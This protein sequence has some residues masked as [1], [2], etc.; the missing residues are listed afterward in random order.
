[1]SET[2]GGGTMNGLQ[3]LSN[4]GAHAPSYTGAA[5]TTRPTQGAIFEAE[6]PTHALHGGSIS[7]FDSGPEPANRLLEKVQRDGIDKGFE[8]LAQGELGKE[9]DSPTEE[10][11]E[12]KEETPTG[13]KS[14]RLSFVKDMKDA[15]KDQI[16]KKE[17]TI[18]QIVREMQELQM[19]N[20]RLEDER[21][22]KQRE[23]SREMTVSFVKA[24]VINGEIMRLSNEIV[25]NQITINVLTGELAQRTTIAA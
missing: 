12:Q 9:P 2:I 3:G 17:R 5:E 1:M 22:A 16:E 25:K 11:S 7:R 8:S 14:P 21:A 13:E 6:H 10:Q 20:M 23:L 4:N 15:A 19:Q 24:Q 18:P